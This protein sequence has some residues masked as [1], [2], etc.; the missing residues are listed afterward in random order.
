MVE[1][2]DVSFEVTGSIG[3]ITLERSQAL[4]ALTLSMIESCA[5]R[6]K[7]WAADPA[8]KA[9]VI[10]GA[11]G[12]AFCA[13][14]DVRAA[15][16][17]GMAAK[18]GSGDGSFTRIFFHAEYSLVRQIR[19]FPKPYIALLDGFTMG[20]GVGIGIH[21]SHPIVTEKTAL[22]MPE[23]G[24]GLF[25]DVGAS[26]FLPRC[27]GSTGT[28]VGLSGARL[29]AA[30][31]IYC[32]LG[33]HHV[34]SDRLE[35]LVTDLSAA[36][37]TNEAQVVVDDIV[38][39]YTE[40]TAPAPLADQQELIDQCFRCDRVEDIFSALASNNSSW[41]QRTLSTLQKMSPTSLKVTLRALR[42]GASMDFDAVIQMEYRLSQACMQR[43]DFYE[44]IRAVLVDKDRSPKWRPPSLAEVSET[45]VEQHFMPLGSHE[46]EF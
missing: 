43:H 3:L 24:I 11:G 21:G 44:G 15:Y 32:G 8:I 2:N 9:V 42:S 36:N 14:G 35:T 22:A 37:W 40:P 33:T 13:G 41:A 17:A 7:A 1:E 45:D 6:L 38:T 23:T 5:Q 16:E 29:G 39:R 26:W 31:V 25:P 28:Y 18:A 12:R 10:Q 19:I 4:N 27:P 46:L 34:P 30:D 20:A